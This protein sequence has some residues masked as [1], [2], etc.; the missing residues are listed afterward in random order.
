MTVSKSH[1]ILF[2]TTVTL[3][4]RLFLRVSS[5]EVGNL[6][7]Y[8]LS[9]RN[10]VTWKVPPNKVKKTPCLFTYY[11]NVCSSHLRIFFH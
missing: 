7:K 1:C 5:D 3:S 9:S 11:F 10:G 6:Q 8:I 4:N 2:H